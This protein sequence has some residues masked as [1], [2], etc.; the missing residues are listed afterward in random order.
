MARRHRRFMVYVHSKGMIVDEE[1]VIVGSANI[2]QR[3]LAG[4]RDT[5]LAVGAYQPHH[6]TAAS[7]AG[8][9]RRPRGKVFGY[10]MSLWEEHLGK[11]VVRRWPELVERPESPECVGLVSR[12][13]RDN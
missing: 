7:A 8:T 4:S 12:I 10:R 9:T 13:A 11:E 5:E 2:N 1:Y 6:T 3:S